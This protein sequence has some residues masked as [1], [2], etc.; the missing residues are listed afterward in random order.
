HRARVMNLDGTRVLITG[1][2]SGIGADLARVLADRGAWL[3]MAARRVDRLD[4]LAKEIEARHPSRRPLT[5]P[6]DLSKRGEGDR[7]G[8]T[9]KAGLGGIDL[10]V[11]NAGGG[12]GGLQ[13]HIGDADAGRETFET[14]VWSPLALVRCL[15]PDMRSRGHGAVVNVTSAAQVMTWP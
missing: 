10:L 11:N 1:A 8:E 3:A 12:L 13:W 15:V 5:I 7:L 2:S 9:A 4:A 14:N 6:C